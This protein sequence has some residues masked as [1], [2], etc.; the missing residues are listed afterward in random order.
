MDN[1]QQHQLIQK[2]QAD[3]SRTLKSEIEKQTAELR[4]V[5]TRLN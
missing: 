3:Y 1:H 5:N 2:Q 4:K